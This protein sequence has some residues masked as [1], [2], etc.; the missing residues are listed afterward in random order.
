MKKL[1]LFLLYLCSTCVLFSQNIIG[2]ISDSDGVLPGAS[3]V[4][5]KNDS[6]IAACL[7]DAEGAFIFNDIPLSKYIISL[8]YI[9]YNTKSDTIVLQGN[10]YKEYTL[11]SSSY[12]LSEVNVT[13]D[14]SNIVKN[15]PHGNVFFLST[16]AK[17]QKDVF[18][19]LR[20]IP[21]LDIDLS[22]KSI[23]LNDGSKP[24]IMV[25]GIER[26]NG[27]INAI[28][29][30]DIEQIEII[31]VA[32]ARYLAEGITSA[33]NI[34]L[35]D[36]PNNEYKYLNTGTVQNPTKALFGVTDLSLDM[37]NNKYSLYLIGQQFYF[38]NNKSKSKDNQKNNVTTK[39]IDVN[40]EASYASYYLQV[41]G[42]L[43]ISKN[44]Y[45][46]YSI[47]YNN[48]PESYELDGSG[49]IYNENDIDKALT[50]DYYKK[51]K[52]KFYI[53]SY[54][55]Y[56]SHIF[57]NKHKLEALVRFNINGS[58]NIGFQEETGIAN[59]Y[60]FAKDFDFKNHKKS[61][62]ININYSFKSLNSHELSVGLKSD[63]QWN[64]IDQ[65]SLLIP[66]FYYKELNN[67]LYADIS[68]AYK[69]KLSYSFSFGYNFTNNKSD[70]IK[71]DY[72]KIRYS[73]IFSYSFNEK[74]RITISNNQYIESPSVNLLNPYNISTDSLI[75]REGNPFL[76]PIT[77]NNLNISY[78]YRLNKI[79]IEPQFMYKRIDN[80]IQ[81][82]GIMDGDVYL[83]KVINNGHF[84]QI[85]P[86]ILFRYNLSFG[87][88]SLF[89]AYN[90]L[91]FPNKK[92]RNTIDGQLNFGLNYKK[93]SFNVKLPLPKKEYSDIMK[94]RSSSESEINIT[95]NINKNWDASIDSRW[96]TG[97]KKYERWMEDQDYSSY[98]LN[99]FNDRNFT[100]LL[101]IR[102]NFKRQGKDKHNTQKLYQEEKGIRLID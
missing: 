72:Q 25:N 46:L 2:K 71:N 11:E 13:S 47:T 50:Y 24:L 17:N 79:I 58:Q 102:Y 83:K 44:D 30:Q 8:S 10:F 78:S 14:R 52:M 33:I 64:K 74:N 22:Y 61:G 39:L 15:S 55:T 84:E 96:V 48:V 70:N 56:Y 3:V 101:G 21:K 37:G 87:Y 53:N 43:N 26:E 9:G 59:N 92:K 38:N 54:N 5:T 99:S 29:P 41:G 97:R 75:I 28:D 63:Y 68:K 62:N 98:Y 76:E 42:D 23:R 65:K 73:A 67:Y 32:S 80:Y 6:V 27:I 51:Y 49:N 90:K 34:K 40:R 7:T 94:V 18:N 45:L 36:K 35:K 85:Q 16:N 95:W 81:E 89:S 77:V 31:E 12:T 57:S 88:I 91:Y 19:A 69:N 93:I 4:I 1:I 60:Y 86:S 66:A 20:E 100:L 82:G